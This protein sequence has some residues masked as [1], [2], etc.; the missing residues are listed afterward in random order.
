MFFNKKNNIFVKVVL[1]IIIVTFVFTTF[2]PV[3]SSF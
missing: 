2:I 3:A 1:V